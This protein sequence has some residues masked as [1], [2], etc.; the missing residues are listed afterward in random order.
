MQVSRSWSLQLAGALALYAGALAAAHASPAQFVAKMYT[1]GLGRAPEPAAWTANLIYT[2]AE[3]NARGYRN[4]EKVLTLFRGLLNREPDAGGLAYWVNY[5]NNGNSMASMVDFVGASIDNGEITS[6]TI[7]ASRGYGWDTH[8][9]LTNKD[10]PVIGAG[11]ADEAGLRAA[12][13]NAKPGTTIS[14]AQRAVI[15]TSKQILVPAGVTLTTTG[16]PHFSQYAKMARIVRSAP[17]TGATEES[18]ALV[19]LNPGAN[20][21]SVWVSGQRQINGYAP[22]A[23]N[24][25]AKSGA[26]VISSRIENSSGWTALVSHRRGHP[27]SGVNFTGNLITGYSNTHLSEVTDGISS[28]CEKTTIRDNAVVDPSDVGIVIFTAIEGDLKAVQSSK[29]YNNVVISA[30]IPAYSAYV[31]DPLSKSTLPGDSSFVGAEFRNNKFWAAPDTHIDIGLA[32][33]TT[34]WFPDPNIGTGGSF[35]G[36]TTAG[37]ATPMQIGI[38]VDGMRAPVVTG[39]TITPAVPRLFPG[40]VSD[41]TKFFQCHAS[42]GASVFADLNTVVNHASGG[43]IQGPVTNKEAHHCVWHQVP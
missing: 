7:C 9:V 18:A 15:S 38:M 35:I 31:L 21:I 40:E 13:Q 14:L 20:L 8:P 4:H 22:N 33:G 43:T 36:N 25:Y 16:S 10:M 24:V 11:I 26:S 17:A 27:C 37:I 6:N 29:A 2:S 32:V 30:G 28:D 5:L 39:N 23:V 1:E 34:A 12:L 41:R 19:F 42:G 3:Y